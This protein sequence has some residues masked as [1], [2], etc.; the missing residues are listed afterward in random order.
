MQ[1]YIINAVKNQPRKFYDIVN[2]KSKLV[3][4]DLLDKYTTILSNKRTTYMKR[5]VVVTWK[6]QRLNN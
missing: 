6:R 1:A 2:K 3:L 4:A 5:N